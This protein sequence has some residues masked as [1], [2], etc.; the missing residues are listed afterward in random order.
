MEH[1]C[2]KVVVCIPSRDLW[3]SDF[4]ISLVHMTNYCTSGYIAE[5]DNFSVF[6]YPRT[7]SSSVIAESRNS[8]VRKALEDPE[9]THVLFVDDDQ[10]FPAD[11]LHQLLRRDLPIVGA[12]VV[13]KEA[14]P[15]TNSRSL[16][17]KGICWTRPDSN[18]VEEVDFVGTGVM[19]IRRDVLEAV[20]DPYFF[21]DMKSGVGEDSG[22]CFAAREKG[23]T[24]HI[25]HD[26]SKQVKHCGHF[27]WGHEHT[28][29][30]QL[31]LRKKKERDTDWLKHGD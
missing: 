6:A 24:V 22:F 20:G 10:V 26:L 19:L 7:E 9:T 27:F 30:W 2:F 5:G 18:G 12:N 1:R 21:Y 11:T 17:H 3:K 31:D 4:G 25:D 15:R 14:N 13:R 29:I 28:D 8:L 16:G 23:F